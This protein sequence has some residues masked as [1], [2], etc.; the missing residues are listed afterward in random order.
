MIITPR[1]LRSSFYRGTVEVNDERSRDSASAWG[2]AETQFFFELTPD[3]ILNAVES[4]GV[5]C[6]GRCLQL[7]SLENRV[8][9]L[10]I[11]VDDESLSARSPERF[12]IVKFY[13]PG[14]WSRE[15]ILEEHNFLFD[16]ADAELPVIAPQRFADGSTLH[17]T[18]HGSILFSMFPKQGGRL[19]DE[20][21]DDEREQLG[22]LVARMHN[23][24]ATKE[25]EHRLILDVETYGWQ[26]LDFI[27]DSGIVP[28]EI[29]DAYEQSA[30]QALE[31]MEPLFEGVPYQRIHGDC[32]C[33]NILWG[34]NGPFM[35]DFDDSVC[36]PC[37]QDLWL[38]TGG[39]GEEG[40]TQREKFLAGYEQ[41]RPFDWA[42]LRLIEPLRT[43]R[44]IH[45]TAWIAKRW[46]D[47]A[48]P[49]AF[50]NFGTPRYWQ[51]AVSD[52]REQCGL[53][54]EARWGGETAY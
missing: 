12:R 43:L 46:S 53:I 27:L 31:T 14:R 17:P 28:D 37:V 52:L 24:G 22:R 29:L 51:E 32:H 26:N 35:V 5:Q 39:S 25:F 41:M 45:F 7:N 8:Y 54:Q 11:E 33:G 21:Q 18:E 48:F 9:E 3:I 10:E 15:Q 1:F 38:L 36:G 6:T 50:P 49:N 30:V 40:R 47:P 2:D 42:A 13:R 16:L 4:A 19:K 23:I 44:Y 34:N 20:L